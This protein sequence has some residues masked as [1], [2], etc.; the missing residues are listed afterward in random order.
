MSLS[1]L[2]TEKLNDYEE[3]ALK[4]SN[5]PEMLDQLKDKILRNKENSNVFKPQIFTNNIEKSYKKVY[6]NFID[7]FSPQDFKL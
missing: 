5:N 1:E 3:K 7:G 2:V 6:Q 4:I